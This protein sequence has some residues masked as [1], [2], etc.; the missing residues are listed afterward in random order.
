[1]PS[2]KTPPDAPSLTHMHPVA[3]HTPTPYGYRPRT[4]R[5]SSLH[6]QGP[7]GV[8]RLPAHLPSPARAQPP[9]VRVTHMQR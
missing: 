3:Q 9:C 2:A 5:P 6:V 7:Q 4:M 1:M 8:T